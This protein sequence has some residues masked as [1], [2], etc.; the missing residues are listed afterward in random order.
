M[1]PIAPLPATVESTPNV[2]LLRRNGWAVNS[3][4]GSYCVAWRGC[5]EIVFQWRNGAWERVG[6]RGGVDDI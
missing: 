3:M 1:Q 2:E 4:F 5:N 6:G